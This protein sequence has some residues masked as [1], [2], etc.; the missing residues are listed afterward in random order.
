VTLD[1]TSTTLRAFLDKVVLGAL[2]FL[3][4]NL[5]N[6]DGF[7]FIEEREE[8]E[9]DEEFEQKQGFLSKPLSSLVGGGIKDGTILAIT[10][11]RQD[12][13]ISLCI[14]HADAASFDEASNP[15]LFSLVG[16]QPASGPSA[17][18]AGAG[19]GAAAAASE[20]A[21]PPLW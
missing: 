7:N 6:G 18:G 16:G 14:C 21:A 13:S 9:D 20:A 12:A 15:L 2:G 8:G 19:A 4:P 17:G 1:V 3:A 5:D 11:W 10:D